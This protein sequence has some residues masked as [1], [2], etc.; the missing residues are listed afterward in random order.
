VPICAARQRIFGT[1]K[2]FE[3]GASIDLHPRHQNVLKQDRAERLILRALGR[4]ALADQGLETL[5]LPAH[6]SLRDES[7]DLS[8]CSVNSRAGTCHIPLKD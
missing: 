6:A 8:N 2:Y 7:I 1:Y 4:A 5:P 3:I